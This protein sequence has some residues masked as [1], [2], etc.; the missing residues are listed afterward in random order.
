[1]KKINEIMPE[2]LLN[3][4]VHRGAIKVNNE[5]YQWTIPENKID[6]MIESVGYE[7]LGRIHSLINEKKKSNK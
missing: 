4:L 7:I 3:G 1:M 2:L 6:E 5:V